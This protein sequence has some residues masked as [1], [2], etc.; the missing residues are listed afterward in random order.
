M[1]NPAL[2]QLRAALPADLWSDDPA[3]IA[4]HL[5][6]W[7]DR[8]IGR[9]QL[10]LLPRGTDEVAQMVRLCSELQVGVVP[11]GGNTGLVGGAMPDGSGEQVLLNLK[12]MDRIRELAPGENTLTA[13][14]GC[15]L[16][17]LQQAAAEADRYLPLSLAS[18]GSSQIGGN[19]S[20][21]A[22]GV[23]VVRYGNARD[24]VLG[25]EVVLPDGAVL[26]TLRALR[27][28]TAGYDLKNLFV[29]AE[30]TLGVITAAVLKLQPRHRSRTTVLLAQRRLEDA[31]AVLASSRSIPGLELLALELM[32]RIGLELVCRHIP[33]TRPPLPLAPPWY[34]LLEL[35]S[36]Q[37]EAP[38]QQR[39]GAWMEGLLAAGQALDGVVAVSQS[40]ADAL[41][42]L[43]ESMSQ[44]QKREGAGLKHDVS[45]PVTRIPELIRGAQERIQRLCPGAR[46][47]AFGHVGDG[48][49]HLNVLQ[50]RRGDGAAFM[51]DGEVITDSVYTLVASLGGSFSAEHG[52]GQLK[53]GELA[54]FRSPVEVGLMRIIKNTLDPKGIM[55]PG[56]LI[57][58]PT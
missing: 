53:R 13:E 50:P 7:R 24:Q 18:E 6:E 57:P 52:I 42:Y 58:E 2:A 22:G 49:V 21:N 8:F 20:S 46:T 31:L 19:L 27:K 12:R 37:P 43:R 11:Q 54:R 40:Q 36:F 10:L 23:N 26:N 56:K 51:A 15:I 55:N 5:V 33:G 16:A 35:G 4:P 9:T 29:G 44:A 34:L 45:V 47:V 48:N 3:L 28:E 30:G 1:S 38:T 39:I 32:P 17:N 14:A 41:W 25:L